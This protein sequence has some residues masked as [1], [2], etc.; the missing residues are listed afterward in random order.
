M[1]VSGLPRPLPE[2]RR[3]AAPMPRAVWRTRKVCAAC[4]TPAER[5]AAV[6]TAH[7]LERAQA[8]TTVRVNGR[9]EA[10]AAKRA[11]RAARSP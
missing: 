1:S 8:A 7:D 10:L 2:C 4:A 9:I 3:C 5:M 11:A 6:Q